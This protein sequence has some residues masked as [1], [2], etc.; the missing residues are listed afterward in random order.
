MNEY[1]QSAKMAH[2]S[3]ESLMSKVENNQSSNVVSLQMAC[4]LSRSQKYEEDLREIN[5]K[6]E[7]ELQDKEDMCKRYKRDLDRALSKNKALEKEKR[8]LEEHLLTGVIRP[9]I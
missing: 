5:E 6:H 3:Y 2:I 4:L 8:D 7:E 1:A 9:F